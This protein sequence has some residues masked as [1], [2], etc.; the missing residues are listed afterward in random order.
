MKVRFSHFVS[1]SSFFFLLLSC[2]EATNILKVNE[3][4]AL[5][6]DPSNLAC[7]TCQLLPAQHVSNC[8]ACCAS[9]RD[10]SM[11]QK[12]YEAAV[13]VVPGPQGVS[14]EIKKLLEEDWD[15]LVEKKG[16][17]RLRLVENPVGSS[18]SYFF[19]MTP[20]Y[21]YF[22][23]DK[24]VSVSTS[25]RDLEGGAQE[26]LVL[27]GWKREDIRDMLQALLP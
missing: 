10:V 23:D 1:S 7:H 20:V 19:G 17:G 25:L 26:T 5:G 2:T 22:F 13:L 3:C 14:E 24:K 16:N 9:F 12:P 11:I 15:T 18:S 6:F 27:N 4:K 21:L 8:Q